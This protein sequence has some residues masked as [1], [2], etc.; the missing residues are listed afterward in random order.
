MN[1]SNNGSPQ[2]DS[3]D[4]KHFGQQ[5][6]SSSSPCGIK[7]QFASRPNEYFGYMCYNF[8]G[9]VKPT[10][11]FKHPLRLVKTSVANS[12]GLADYHL[13]DKTTMTIFL[14]GI[15]DCFPFAKPVKPVFRDNDDEDAMLFVKVKTDDVLVYCDKKINVLWDVLPR[16]FE[17]R[18]A[19]QVNGVKVEKKTGQASFMVKM[20]QV[21]LMDDGATVDKATNEEKYLF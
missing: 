17:G 9:G 21:L 3:A 19:L 8:R 11:V 18:V 15:A 16:S 7:Y 2:E 1:S 20:I 14:N 12:V 5:G 6:A 4:T 13:E 10:Y